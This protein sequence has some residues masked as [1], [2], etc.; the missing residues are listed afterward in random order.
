M[1]HGIEPHVG[2]YADRAEPAQDCFSLP[3]LPPSQNKQ[4]LKKEISMSKKYTI[5]IQATL[6]ILYHMS[7]DFPKVLFSYWKQDITYPIS[8][9]AQATTPSV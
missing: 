3:L 1:V 4:T 6:K 2:L 7:S 5:T 8:P 9:A